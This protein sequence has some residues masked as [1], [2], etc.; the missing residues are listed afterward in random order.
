MSPE[1]REVLNQVLDQIYNDFCT[2]VGQARHIAPDQVKALIDGGPF[3]G[4]QA[5]TNNGLIDQ[6]AYED[7]VYSDLKK[8][9]GDSNLNKVSIKN[10]FRVTSAKGDRIA[11]LVGAKVKLCAAIRQ[12]DWAAIPAIFPLA[13]FSRIIRQ[14]RQ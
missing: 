14:V 7:Q 9:T 4:S 1:T 2:K 3:M 11:I 12:T 8:R 5:K 6:L 13:V 10:Y